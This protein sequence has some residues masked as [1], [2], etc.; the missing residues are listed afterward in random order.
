M[1]EA[2]ID[3]VLEAKA[4]AEA[5]FVNQ[6]AMGTPLDPRQ[7]AEI[8][9]AQVQAIIDAEKVP[10]AEPEPVVTAEPDPTPPTEEAS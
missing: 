5:P 9:I 1:D 8:L 4:A 7:V 3:H 10:A 2:L 6:V